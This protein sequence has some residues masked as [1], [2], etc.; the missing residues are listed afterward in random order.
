M[1]TQ[2]A[3]EILDGL[4][5]E[6]PGY[7]EGVARDRE[8]LRIA[9]LVYEA[10]TAAGLSQKQLAERINSRQS[11]IS[12]LEDADYTGHSLSLLQRIA[13]ALNCTLE[14]RLIPAAPAAPL[15]AA[16]ADQRK[17]LARV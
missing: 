3:V 12:R 4:F 10:R 2:D 6:A 17:T 1:E 9:H 15:E 11:V 7:R 8:R 16:R 13:F 14:V 5:G